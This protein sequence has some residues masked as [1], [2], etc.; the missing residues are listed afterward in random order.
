MA[1][2]AVSTADR[3]MYGLGL[4]LS[5]RCGPMYLRET[6]TGPFKDAAT[7]SVKLSMVIGV[8]VSYVVGGLLDNPMLGEEEENLQATLAQKNGVL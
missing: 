4:G 6:V 8:I 1:C 3:L 7:V 2:R 5:L